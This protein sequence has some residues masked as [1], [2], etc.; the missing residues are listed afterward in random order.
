M[1]A[2]IYFCLQPIIIDN[3][4]ENNLQANG[5]DNLCNYVDLNDL[6]IAFSDDPNNEVKSFTRIVWYQYCRDT[7]VIFQFSV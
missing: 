6:L 4:N 3:T 7:K 5:R 1:S 2:W